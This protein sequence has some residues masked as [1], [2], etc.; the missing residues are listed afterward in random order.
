MENVYSY[1]FKVYIFVYICTIVLM[2]AYIYTE[3]ISRYAYKYAYI[4]ILMFSEYARLYEYGFI[5]RW[6]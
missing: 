1:I 3:I 4:Y 6:F 2:Y 5:K